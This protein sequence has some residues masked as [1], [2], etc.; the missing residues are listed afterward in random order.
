MKDRGCCGERNGPSKNSGG[1]VIAAVTAA[2]RS[3]V[4]TMSV[5]KYMYI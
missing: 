5:L 2:K 1:T 4:D 3:T